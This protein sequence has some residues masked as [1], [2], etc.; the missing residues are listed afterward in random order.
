MNKSR[1]PIF[2]RPF[3]MPQ[4][5]GASDLPGLAR[6]YELA[7]SLFFVAHCHPEE[8][9]I[10]QQAL[11]VDQIRQRL[12][13]IHT[14][15]QPLADAGALCPQF[16]DVAKMSDWFPRGVTA[17]TVASACSTLHRLAARSGAGSETK[18]SEKPLTGKAK[19]AA[20]LITES[21]GLKGDDIARRLGYEHGESFRRLFIEKLKPRG[22]H[23]D[24]GYRPPVALQTGHKLDT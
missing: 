8:I 13:E 3:T 20:D 17:E 12:R 23:N 11:D 15:F 24:D 1:D 4:Q 21:P 5:A 22:F 9:D 19:E 2:M 18:S 14:V 6:E 7:V 16:D 10:A